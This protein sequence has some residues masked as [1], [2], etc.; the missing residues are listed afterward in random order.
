MKTILRLAFTVFSCFIIGLWICNVAYA[1]EGNFTI[2]KNATVI[3]DEAFCDCAAMKYVT[4]PIGVRRISNNAFLGCDNLSR[5]YFEGTQ[6]QWK[7]ISIAVGNEPL[8]T[9]MCVF[10]GDHPHTMIV[11][12]GGKNYTAEYFGRVDISS[13]SDKYAYREFWHLENA[14][15]DFKDCF[16]T[17][18]FRSGDNLSDNHYPMPI[19]VGQ[20]YMIDYVLKNGGTESKLMRCDGSIWDGKLMTHEIDTDKRISTTSFRIN[21]KTY[22][23]SYYGRVDIT[24]LEGYTC[25]DFWRLEGAYND[26]KDSVLTGEWLP[27]ESYPLCVEAEQVYVIDY[28][29]QDG[30][31]KRA[32]MRCDGDLWEGMLNTHAVLADAPA[33]SK[34]IVISGKTY[35]ANY[36]GRSDISSFERYIC[37]DFWRLEGAYNDFKDSRRIGDNLPANNYPMNVEAGQVYLIDYYQKDGRA[38]HEVMR[39]D[40]NIKD[41][42]LITHAI[43]VDVAPLYTETMTIGGKNYT[44]SYFG[45]EPAHSPWND[46]YTCRE[47]W[48]L[49][50]A[51]QAL[52]TAP[53]AGDNLPANNYNMLIEA[54]Q[55]YVI[56]YTRRDG[57]MYREVMR[58][59]GNI[60][61]G[62]L[63]THAIIVD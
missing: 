51:Y 55:V 2:P 63:I 58:C 44:A 21:G 15:A 22:T 10:L 20:V 12:I 1:D 23:A 16:R 9:A 56:D 26:F 59:D 24:R 34:S 7:R 40:G 36:Y 27:E 48:R 57:S 45:W 35:T 33:Y 43:A 3:E 30:S 14:Y 62:M 37:R 13:W 53:L 31:K 61:D 29:M 5:V 41:G 19:E 4:I 6:A 32:I 54:G 11:R 42:M 52:R 38:Y 49:E 8:G 47:F 25:R 50:N 46:K 17:G 39:C 28:T 60:R 18:D